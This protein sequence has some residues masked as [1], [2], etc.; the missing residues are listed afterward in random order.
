VDLTS[1]PIVENDTLHLSLTIQNLTG[2]S[3][4]SGVSFARELWLEMQI[5]D[6][7]QVYFSTGVLESDSSNLSSDVEVFNSVL[8]DEDGNAGVGVT[9][10]ISMSNN[11][12]QTNEAKVR[13]FSLPLA[14][15]GDSVSVKARL[16]FRSFSP[17][18][19]RDNHP[20]LL[21]NLPVITVDS[22]SINI[23]TP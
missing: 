5:F 12:L 13:T 21:A 22:L 11:S 14:G 7:S 2:H 1:E 15:V 18:T 6:D 9:D 4:P 3:F 17:S 20:D 19:L 23:A 8:Y 10:V 16:L